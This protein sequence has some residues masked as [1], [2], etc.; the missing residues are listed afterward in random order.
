MHTPTIL[1]VLAATMAVS[2]ALALEQRDTGH[3]NNGQSANKC[4]NSFNTLYINLIP[5]TL[6]IGCV[7]SKLDCA[8][9]VYRL[10]ELWEIVATNRRPA[11]TIQR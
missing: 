4:C 8:V 1:I 3:W 11:A 9:T 7:D 6:G 10:L 2:A 5:I